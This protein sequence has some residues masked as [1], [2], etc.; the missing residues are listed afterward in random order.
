MGK[1]QRLPASVVNQ[2]AAGEV[3]ERPASVVKELLE[4]AVDSG[5]TRIDLA[6]GI[7]RRESDVLNDDIARV[8]GVELAEGAAG[9]GFVLAGGAKDLVTSI[10]KRER[11]RGF[12]VDDDTGNA[13]MG[14]R[15]DNCRRQNQGCE[16]RTRSAFKRFHNHDMSP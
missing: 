12:R 5:A 8:L 9:D 11:W 7:A 10:G 13:R 2:I 1:I 16:N 6:V 4:N 14:N 3:V 15:R